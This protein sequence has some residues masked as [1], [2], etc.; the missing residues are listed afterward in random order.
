[1]AKSAAANATAKA[2]ASRAQAAAR[3]AEAARQNAALEM[4]RAGMRNAEINASVA[5]RDAAEAERR[6]LQAET[7]HV[8]AVQAALLANTSNM[9]ME[10]Q[11]LERRRQ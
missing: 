6:R 2:E 3:A 11:S 7:D 1:M 10:I 5:I 8:R 9:Q 4:F